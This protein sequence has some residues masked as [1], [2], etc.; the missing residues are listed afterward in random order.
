MTFD[1]IAAGY[2][3]ALVAGLGLPGTGVQLLQP[4]PVPAD[5]LALWRLLDRLPSAT[6][7]RDPGAPADSL[8]GTYRRILA[9]LEIPAEDRFTA[10]VGRRI[11]DEFARF[12]ASRPGRPPSATAYPALFRNWAL[13]H[14]PAVAG[15]G[16][17]ALAGMIL[18]PL[19]AAT[20]ALLPYL[21]TTAEPPRPGR[22]PDWDDTVDDV[23]AALKAAPSREF[24]VDSDTIVTDTAGELGEPAGLW[25]LSDPETEQARRFAAAEFRLR[26]SAG[27]VLLRRPVPGPWFSSAVLGIAHATPDG[28]PWSPEGP[29][30][31]TTAFGILRYVTNALIVV[32]S[33]EVTVE[34][35]G[36]YGEEDQQII[37]ANLGHGLWPLYL[38]GAD[39]SFTPDGAMTVHLATAPGTPVVLGV[40]ALTIDA[41]LGRR[42]PA[43]SAG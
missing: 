33:L 12:L 9:S 13:L 35:A 1:D 32:D 41:Y 20:I 25:G 28:P 4:A 19:G 10:A 5:D 8:S 21:D 18:E 15:R 23:T 22:A 14:H 29:L 27:H 2:A 37:L 42:P 7:Y 30:D 17:T 31:W 38:P 26:V 39:C 16:T 3:T 43:V 34:S 24:T 40:V 11:A 36:P 6:L